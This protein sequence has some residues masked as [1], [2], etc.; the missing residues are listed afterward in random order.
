MH[1]PYFENNVPA[2]TSL[3]IQT[4]ELNCE[5]V[6]D[7]ERDLADL[8]HRSNDEVFKYTNLISSR[9]L[10]T[11]RRNGIC[12]PTE[13]ENESLWHRI[14]SLA[15]WACLGAGLAVMAILIADTLEL[16]PLYRWLII[17]ST[18]AGF[19]IILPAYLVVRTRINYH[20]KDPIRKLGWELGTSGLLVVFGSLTWALTRG[21][22]G[23]NDWTAV[24]YAASGPVAELGLA[25]GSACFWILAK[26]YCATDV[27]ART[28]SSIQQNI[29]EAVRRQ[30]RAF[31]VAV[32]AYSE[33]LRRG[34]ADQI[35]ISIRMREALIEGIERLNN[36]GAQY[37][38]A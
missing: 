29:F 5:V 12:I 25:I 38:K 27:S 21:T 13:N 24:A 30:D 18:V 34:V 17:G 20:T 26:H 22:S 10:L 3:L 2:E 16:P 23:I 14:F 11:F 19:A 9:G 8:R 4:V 15:K 31:A 33:L 37:A 36:G 35:A 32:A 6:E 28:Y 7:A 1:E